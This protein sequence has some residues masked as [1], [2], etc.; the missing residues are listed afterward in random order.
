[1][2]RRRAGLPTD[3]DYDT[4]PR[5]SSSPTRKILGAGTKLKE[6][7]KQVVSGTRATTEDTA[8]RGKEKAQREKTRGEQKIETGKMTGK[9]AVREAAQDVSKGWL[10]PN[11]DVYE[12]EG[13]LIT[14]EI[15]LPGIPVENI[16]LGINE[17]SAIVS[18]TNLKATRARG[19]FFQ[20]ERN[21]GSFYR[22]IDLS[23]SVDTSKVTAV[24]FNGLLTVTVPRLGI[25]PIRQLG[26]T[27][28]TSTV[29]QSSFTQP[30]MTQSG[31]T[32]SSMNQPSMTQSGFN[33]PSMMNQPSMSQPS[34]TGQQYTSTPEYTKA[35]PT[36][37]T[38]SMPQSDGYTH[39]HHGSLYQTAVV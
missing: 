20:N 35:M 21:T 11:V 23:T 26:P 3:D 18:A 30:S 17:K 37:V 29:N 5:T 1:M 27:A 33:Q 19:F 22:K 9:E 2:N 38:S 31:F 15:E 16:S 8:E 24:L 25:V 10:R 12:Q 13:G 39:K 36:Y 14:I 6:G 7:I 34:W 32:Q 4:T 28:Q